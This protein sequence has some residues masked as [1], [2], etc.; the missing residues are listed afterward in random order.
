MPFID[1]LSAFFLPHPTCKPSPLHLFFSCN[2]QLATCKSRLVGSTGA[3]GGLA[4]CNLQV[5]LVVFVVE[6]VD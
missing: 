6:F 1:E 3:P 4:T 5:V 2:L